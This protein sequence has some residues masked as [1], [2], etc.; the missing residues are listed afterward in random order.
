MTTASNPIGAP[1]SIFRDDIPERR[2]R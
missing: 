2:L 1:M